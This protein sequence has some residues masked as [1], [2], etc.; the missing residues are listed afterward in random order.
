ML[1]KAVRKR[2]AFFVFFGAWKN[3]QTK[4]APCCNG[5]HGSVV[6]GGVTSIHG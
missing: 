2:A 6:K 5:K 4:N 3:Y 1:K